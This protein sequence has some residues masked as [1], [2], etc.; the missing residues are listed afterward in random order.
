MKTVEKKLG[1]LK[2]I[3]KQEDN[4]LYLEDLILQVNNVVIKTNEYLGTGWKFKEG[5]GYWTNYQNSIIYIC[6]QEPLVKDD[7]RL[8]IISIFHEIAHSK[9]HLAGRSDEIKHNNY[10][11]L[12]TELEAWTESLKMLENFNS[13]LPEAK[14]INKHVFDSIKSQIDKTT[15]EC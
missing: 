3:Y 4:S 15:M 1:P 5:G 7:Q 11:R 8:H 14:I 12:I 9:I 6:L 10:K 13:V 2:I